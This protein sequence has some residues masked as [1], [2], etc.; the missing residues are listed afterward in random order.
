MV[1]RLIH[2]SEQTWRE[3]VRMLAGMPL[4]RENLLTEH[5]SDGKGKCRKC[6]TPGRGTPQAPWPC[7][8]WK[9]ADAA[10]KVKTR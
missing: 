9:L 5:V 6:T 8:L 7:T 1:L 4:A 2:P 3:L 10:G